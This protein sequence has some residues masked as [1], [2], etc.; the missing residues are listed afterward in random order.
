MSQWGQQPGYQ[1]PL[2]TGFQPQFQQIP[3]FQQQNPQFQQQNPQ[4]QQ[5]NPQFQQQNPQFQPNFTG[6]PNQQTGFLGGNAQQPQLRPP[7]V[8]P[9]PS[10]FSLLGLPQ[11]QPPNRLSPGLSGSTGSNFAAPGPLVP[12]VTGFVDPRLQMMSTTFMPVS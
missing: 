1:Y 2:Q 7:P 11:Q 6:L 8:P 3:Q 12:A 4:F 5:Q 10:Q 9:I